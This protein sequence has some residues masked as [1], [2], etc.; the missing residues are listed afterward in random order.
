MDIRDQ[1]VVAD[2]FRRHGEGISLFIHKAAQPSHDWVTK[3]P[4]CRLLG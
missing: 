3:A 1:G 4:F 2:L